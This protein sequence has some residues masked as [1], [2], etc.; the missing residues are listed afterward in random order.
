MSTEEWR[1][2]PDHAGY[3]TN[4]VDFRGI[5]RIITK[6][7]GVRYAVRGRKVENQQALSVGVAGRET[8]HRPRRRRPVALRAPAAGRH[9]R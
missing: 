9:V 3:E 4:G 6:S 5:D 7:D 2:I 1:P 8:V